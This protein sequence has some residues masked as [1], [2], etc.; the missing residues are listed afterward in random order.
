[1][2]RRRRIGV[3]VDMIAS[4]GREIAA[5]VAAYGHLRNWEL[6]TKPVWR[7]NATQLT[8]LFEA[9]GMIL[10]LYSRD[11]LERIVAERIPVVNVSSMLASAAVPS[12][13]VD[14]PAIGRLAA[15]HL[16]E[17]P[18]SAL[19]I[20]VSPLDRDLRW[21]QDRSRTF[22]QIAAGAGTPVYAV[23][24]NVPEAVDVLRSDDPA[25]K[26]RW[27]A[28]LPRPMG[29]FAG[30]DY[31]ALEVLQDCQD[32]GLAVPDDA[33]V[34]GCDN[35]ELLNRFARPSLSTIALDFERQGYL[36]AQLLERCL[37]GE[38]IEPQTRL[39]IAPSGV[40]RRESTD[41]AAVRDPE[42]SAAIAFIQRNAHE[43]ITVNDVVAATGVSRRTLEYRF[44]DCRRRTILQEILRERVDRAKRLLDETDFKLDAVA[45]ACGFGSR[46]RLYATFRE[47]VGMS[48]EKWR[49]RHRIAT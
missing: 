41:Q 48:P 8:G 29:I 42:V 16:L 21:A 46:I 7:M 13:L 5:G 15:E 23:A 34:L 24:I 17:S 3:L 31:H 20:D 40:I 11:L 47:L 10:S 22:A 25:D 4:H 26:R 45:R 2:A 30:N 28:A 35:D 1:M 39:T 9:D 43:R 12:V 36:A 44:R 32:A 37:D 14:S 18:V 33:A 27:L 38:P 19:V 6:L 49:A